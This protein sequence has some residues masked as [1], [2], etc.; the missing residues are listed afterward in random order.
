MIWVALSG[1]SE[2]AL[3]QE[4]LGLLHPARTAGH[5]AGRSRVVEL[6]TPQAVSTIGASE[7]MRVHL[8]NGETEEGCPTLFRD[9]AR[10]KS[11]GIDP[12]TRSERAGI[13]VDPTAGTATRSTKRSSALSWTYPYY[14]AK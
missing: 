9:P 3:M 14:L 1:N 12:S 6:S 11:G 13:E 7:I 8:S 10:G 4:M 5:R 2:S